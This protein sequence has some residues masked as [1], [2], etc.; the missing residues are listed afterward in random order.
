MNI[1]KGEKLPPDSMG[2]EKFI[3]KLINL[4]PSFSPVSTLIFNKDGKRGL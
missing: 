4:T 3:V 1:W 2:K